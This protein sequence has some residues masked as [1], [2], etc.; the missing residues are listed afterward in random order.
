MR[1]RLYPHVTLQ[2]CEYLHRPNENFYYILNIRFSIEVLQMKTEIQAKLN[3]FGDIHHI[4]RL[5]LQKGSKPPEF[6]T[7]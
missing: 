7:G 2:S 4:R 6:C 1:S 3:C 5:F